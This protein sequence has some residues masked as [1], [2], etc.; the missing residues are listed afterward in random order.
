MKQLL[1]ALLILAAVVPAHAGWFERFCRRNFIDDDPYQFESASTE[2]LVERYR[3]EGAKTYWIQ[4]KSR[5]LGLMGAE[6][7]R[8][9]RFKTLSEESRKTLEDYARFERG[10]Q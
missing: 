7:R 6:L 4:G 5:L 2:Y 1:T 8:E 9:Y 10:D 3:A